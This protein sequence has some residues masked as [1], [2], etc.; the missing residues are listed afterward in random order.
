M[1]LYDYITS[2]VRNMSN[3][4]CENIIINVQMHEKCDFRINFAKPLKFFRTLTIL[5]MDKC[6]Q[7][8][9]S[10]HR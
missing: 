10:G 5:Y 1:S 8:E 2:F 3:K 7:K 4:R 9:P 6:P